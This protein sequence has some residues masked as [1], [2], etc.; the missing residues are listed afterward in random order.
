MS[1]AKFI[2]L[3]TFLF[4]CG[5]D[6]EIDPALKPLL[7]Y[8]LSFAPNKGNVDQLVSFRF[9]T[10]GRTT[11]GSCQPIGNR[12]RAW[13]LVKLPTIREIIV[14]TP[15]EGFEYSWKAMV[16]HEL[17]HCLHNKGHSPTRGDIM[18]AHLT[19][20]NPEEDEQYW[21]E[22]LEAEMHEMFPEEA[23]P[24]KRRRNLRPLLD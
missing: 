3:G 16:M 14:I 24:E 20:E 7:D 2:L 13:G 23:I 5:V 18:Y 17:G 12:K 11:E 1:W 6:R 4:G 8:Y 22:N 21:K 9:G 10:L 15:E 19:G